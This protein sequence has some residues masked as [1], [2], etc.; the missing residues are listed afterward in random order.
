MT[1]TDLS[2]TLIG[3][4]SRQEIAGLVILAPLNVVIWLNVGFSE[5]RHARTRAWIAVTLLYCMWTVQ[6]ATLGYVT[7]LVTGVNTTVF[8][9]I[10]FYRWCIENP[11]TRAAEFCA[12]HIPHWHPPREDEL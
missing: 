9:I 6:Y 12:A 7:A 10:A 11:D 8:G 1:T 2:M 3:D 4:L 5:T